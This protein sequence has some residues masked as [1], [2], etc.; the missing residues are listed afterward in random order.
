MGVAQT[1]KSAAASGRWV[2]L[3][4][5]GE[6]KTFSSSFLSYAAP[7]SDVSLRPGRAVSKRAAPARIPWARRRGRA[8]DIP[9][10]QD[11]A[12]APA[13]QKK[14]IDY[15]HCLCPYVLE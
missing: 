9:I 15:V 11:N 7:Y 10:V 4:E 1:S 12:C 13:C 14:M 2:V 3:L 5:L 8:R 6:L